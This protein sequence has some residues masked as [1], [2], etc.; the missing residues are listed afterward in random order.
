M[1]HRQFD[2]FNNYSPTLSYFLSNE[3]II[4]LSTRIL[5]YKKEY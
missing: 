1:D 4:Y 2:E 3:P 5:N